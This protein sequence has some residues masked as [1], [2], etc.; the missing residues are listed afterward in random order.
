MPFARVQISPLI[1][2]GGSV[3]WRRP[4][5]AVRSTNAKSDIG[6][7]SPQ[8]LPCHIL[9]VLH[10]L[11]AW[12]HDLVV[13]GAHKAVNRG[14]VRLRP[15]RYEQTIV[16][17]RESGHNLKEPHAAMTDQGTPEELVAKWRS[18]RIQVAPGVPEEQLQAFEG[19]FG[20][21]LAGT[22]REYLRLGCGMVDS[23]WDHELVHFWTLDE[24]L[25]HLIEPDSLGRFPFLPFA[26][27]S[28][29]CWVWALPIGSKGHVEDSVCTYGPPLHPCAPSFSAFI[30]QYLRGE[31]ISP[32]ELEHPVRLHWKAR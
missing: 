14:R 16:G 6:V 4:G 32:K 17:G 3:D 30:A 28:I 7:R 20:L 9:A 15:R 29:N 12:S 27:Y 22:F 1:R 8:A 24:I 11:S 2:I 13:D 26:D 31:D 18:E 5:F 10:M 19:R 25:T 23:G 21:R